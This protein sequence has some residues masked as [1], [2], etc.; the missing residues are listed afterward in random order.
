MLTILWWQIAISLKP[1]A[2]D[3]CDFCSWELIDAKVRLVSKSSWQDGKGSKS[4]V[5]FNIWAGNVQ[6]YFLLQKR[7][8]SIAWSRR[9]SIWDRSWS[10]VNGVALCSKYVTICAAKHKL[11]GRETFPIQSREEM[12]LALSFCRWNPLCPSQSW[13]LTLEN[14]TLL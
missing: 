7:P 11:G 2:V 9:L 12:H 3:C 5:V 13:L 6:C 4:K 10:D 8:A 1:A 14:C